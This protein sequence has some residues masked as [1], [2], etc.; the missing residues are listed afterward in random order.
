MPIAASRHGAR[1]K[2]LLA[3]V[4][5]IVV[6]FV[7]FRDRERPLVR[8][9]VAVLDVS[10]YDDPARDA[11]PVEE[12]VR[13]S[14]R[15]PAGPANI[16]VIMADDLGY[17]DLGSYGNTVLRTPNLDRLA[18]G[19]V[20]MTGFYSSHSFCSPSRAGLLTG[21]YPLRTGINFPIQPADDSLLRRIRRV[22]GRW[23]AGI[24]ATDLVQAGQSAFPGLPLSEI[25]LPEALRVAGYATGMVGKWHLGDFF[26]DPSFHPMRHGFDSFT[27]MQGSNDE[28][29]YRLWKDREVVE[30][31]LGLRQGDVT[32]RLTDAAVEF[33]DA[34]RAKPFFLYFAHKNVHTP[35]VPSP[36]FEGRS[37][38][39]A[40]GDSV[41]ELDASVGE[42]VRALEERGLL[43]RTLVVFTS[44]NGPW[45]LG[46]PG[47]LRGRKGQPMEGGQR[48]PMIAH[49]PGRLPAG[50]VAA[51]P[52]MNF[53]LFPTI[54]RLVGLDLPDDR[55]IDGR[56]LWPLLA[57]ESDESPHDALF[58]FNANVV[59]GA[60][61]GRWKY[62]RW[63]NLYTWPVPLDKPNTLAGRIAHG[64]AYTDP[65][66]GRTMPLIT[67]DPLLFDVEADTNES[68][69]V[70]ERHPGEAARILQ[71]IEAWERDFFANP[72]GWRD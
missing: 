30:E 45:H 24:G 52:A 14:A 31:N 23:S 55:A 65:Q 53:D 58:F 66:T 16:V 35:L 3:V 13:R 60:R 69:D 56:D 25:T 29:P 48:V 63:V 17:G 72:R 2:K 70:S 20:R 22:T 11:R 6:A 43:E 46:N 42:V 64:H 32:R 57:G 4:L 38:A 21:R 50:R 1:M 10:V 26:S 27:G 9:G 5:V 12:V 49:W 62:Y 40:Y 51:A 41:E 71:A 61:A 34:N 33:I 19:G 54:F 67:H 37:A 68:Y 39:G 59:D 36:E 28:F 44:D 47:A 7:L 15:A 8:D 18:E